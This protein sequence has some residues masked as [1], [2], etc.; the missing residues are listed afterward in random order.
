M[1]MSAKHKPISV[2]PWRTG[3]AGR[4]VFAADKPK[5]VAACRAK[6]DAAYI[7]HACNAY[8]ELVA[9][10]RAAVTFAAAND[11]YAR[12]CGEHDVIVRARATLAK[13]GEAP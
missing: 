1:K 2:A 4:T 11:S 3:D 13:L 9:A 12:M 8:P 6:G 7:A 10:L 5:V